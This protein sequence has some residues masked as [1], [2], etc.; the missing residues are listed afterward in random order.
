MEE[1]IKESEWGVLGS[2]LKMVMV[3]RVLEVGVTMSGV[4]PVGVV[5]WLGDMGSILGL[6][7]LPWLSILKGVVE[8]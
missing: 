5:G 4:I 7:M 8:W 2:F 3:R 1:P 6:T